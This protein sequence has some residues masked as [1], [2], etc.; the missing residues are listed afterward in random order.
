ML[1]PSKAPGQP[2]VR[3]Q[4]PALSAQGWRSSL[5]PLPADEDS[6]SGLLITL[7]KYS[8]S[9]WQGRCTAYLFVLGHPVEM[10]LPIH[11]Q[12]QQVT[13]EGDL[14]EARQTRVL[15][16]ACP[17]TTSPALTLSRRRGLGVHS[18]R[19][20]VC[21][22]RPKGTHMGKTHHTQPSCS[23]AQSDGCGDDSKLPCLRDT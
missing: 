13:E 18:G 11:V 5:G 17:P 7:P 2:G 9:R 22:P 19:P 21:S 15:A 23:S 3:V 16:P 8:S 6:R 4:R 20:G 14:G 1:D 10:G 12:Q